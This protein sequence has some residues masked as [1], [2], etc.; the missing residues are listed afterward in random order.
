MTDVGPDSE[1]ENWQEERRG[2]ELRV[3][4]TML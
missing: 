3:G 2:G 4:D 1:R